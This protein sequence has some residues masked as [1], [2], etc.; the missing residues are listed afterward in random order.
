ME[1]CGA[2]SVSDIMRLR[3][4]TLTEEEIATVLTDTLMG[5]E[6]L[7]ARKKIH[8]DIKAGNILLNSEGHAK[9]ADFGVAGQLTVSN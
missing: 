4:K 2:G 5:L 1:Y 6:Y 3:K 8:R 9:L 7:H